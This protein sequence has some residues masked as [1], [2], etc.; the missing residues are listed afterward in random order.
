MIKILMLLSNYKSAY[1]NSV[2]VVA[3]WK[4]EL[5]LFYEIKLITNL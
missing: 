3:M 1:D 5:K 4:Q 2:D